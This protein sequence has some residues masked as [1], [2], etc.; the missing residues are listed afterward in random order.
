[1]AEKL[2]F[3]GGRGSS[4]KKNRKIAKKYR[5]IKPLPRGTNGKKTEK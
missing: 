2:N 5:N 4:G 3:Q 1:L